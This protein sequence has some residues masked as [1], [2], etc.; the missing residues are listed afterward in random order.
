MRYMRR[1]TQQELKRM[2]ARRQFYRRFSLATTEMKM[3]FVFRYRDV[4][5]RQTGVDQ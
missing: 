3:M 1:V 4:E 2:P 5:I